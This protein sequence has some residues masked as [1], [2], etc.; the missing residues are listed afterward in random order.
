MRAVFG[1][2]PSASRAKLRI[3]S[4]S[5]SSESMVSMSRMRGAC[6]RKP[7][8][9]LQPDSCSTLIASGNIALKESR[10]LLTVA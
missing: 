6:G 8:A 3:A 10:N 5:R 4:S 9:G 2:R 7:Q 1:V